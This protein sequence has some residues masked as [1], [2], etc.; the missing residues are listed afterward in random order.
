MGAILPHLNLPSPLQQRVESLAEIFGIDEEHAMLRCIRI[1]EVLLAVG[2]QGGRL[3]VELNGS[4]Y[5]FEVGNPT[6]PI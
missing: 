1:T 6:I 4:Q 5:P 3:L 2:E